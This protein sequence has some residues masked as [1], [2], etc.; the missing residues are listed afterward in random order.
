[1]LKFVK[2]NLVRLGLVRMK[3][4][5]MILVR[6]SFVRL[7]LVRLGSFTCKKDADSDQKNKIPKSEKSG[8]QER[9]T[10]N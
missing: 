6:L 8:F 4:M 9:I 7:G 2:L 5:K 3:L 10:R 1:M